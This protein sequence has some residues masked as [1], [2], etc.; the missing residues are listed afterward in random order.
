MKLALEERLGAKLPCGH[1][2]VTWLAEHAATTLAKF[3]DHQDGDASCQRL[4]GLPCTDRLADFG[5]TAMPYIPAGMRANM[6]PR[7]EL[8]I[9]LGKPWGINIILAYPIGAVT[10]ARAIA[11]CGGEALTAAACRDCEPLRSQRRPATSIRLSSY[12]NVTQQANHKT[13]SIIN[14]KTTPMMYAGS[15][16]PNKTYTTLAFLIRVI[17]STSA[18]PGQTT[19][20]IMQWRTWRGRARFGV[21]C[22]PAA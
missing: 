19:E 14:T 8:S 2:I 15:A 9:Y 6:D 5:E 7:W 1:P 4:H 12:G 22:M 10:R 3:H 21:D 18:A 13:R 11:G 17:N 20:R 16:L